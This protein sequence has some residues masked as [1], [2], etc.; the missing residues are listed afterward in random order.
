MMHH[1]WTPA[2]AGVTELSK[3]CCKTAGIL[4]NTSL[5]AYSVGG[6]N[7]QYYE[8]NDHVEI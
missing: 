2:F 4:L 3:Y 1:N 6:Q 8:S 5:G 7:F